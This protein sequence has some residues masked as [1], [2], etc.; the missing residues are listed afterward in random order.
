MAAK[1]VFWRCERILWECLNVHTFQNPTWCLPISLSYWVPLKTWPLGPL[2]WNVHLFSVFYLLTMSLRSHLHAASK[3]SFQCLS[4]CR[5]V[6][7]LQN[8]LDPHP[9]FKAGWTLSVDGVSYK[10][11]NGELW[12]PT[13]NS[14]LFTASLEQPPSAV[15]QGWWSMSNADRRLVSPFGNAEKGWLW[16]MEKSW[17]ILPVLHL[18]IRLTNRRCTGFL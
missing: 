11:E 9:V 14:W 12:S 18:E 16:K 6:S 8:K 5:G 13:Q 4:L 15:L 1:W 7:W 3:V 17:R 10:E 2:G